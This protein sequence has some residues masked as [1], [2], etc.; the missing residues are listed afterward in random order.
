MRV[1]FKSKFKQTQGFG[2]NPQ[3]YKQFGLAGHEGGDYIPTGTVWDVLCL[4]DGVVVRDIDDVQLGKNYGIN[5]TV[6]HPL[7]RKATQY[8]HLASNNVSMGQRL[9][10]GDKIGVMGKTGNTTGNHVH[11]N[12]FLTDE[13]GMRLNRDNGYFGGIDPLPFLEED[14][15]TPI[16]TVPVP[17]PQFEDFERVKIIYNKIREKL[18]V[19]DSEI[20]VLGEIEKL[21]GYEDSVLQKDKQIIDANTKITELGNSLNELIDTN[22]KLIEDNHL[23]ENQIREQ[24]IVIQNQDDHI[25]ILGEEIKQLKDNV[26]KQAPT[27]W[28][29]FLID[30]ISKL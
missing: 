20:V 26:Q 12:L 17:R 24:G 29:K 3:Y 18:N 25:K 23:L 2:E 21:I 27:G 22:K 1:L 4:E 15:S 19:E 5:V 11:L 7:I 6:L 30:F 13:N 16:D 8:C 14:I 9:K 28:K 10:R